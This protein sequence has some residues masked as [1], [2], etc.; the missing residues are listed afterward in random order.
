MSRQLALFFEEVLFILMTFFSFKKTLHIILIKKNA[1]LNFF[2]LVLESMLTKF[3][4]LKYMIHLS[5]HH[6][7]ITLFFLEDSGV[8]QDCDDSAVT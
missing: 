3:K 8:V 2:Q 6:G 7:Y 1:R 4:C 5:V